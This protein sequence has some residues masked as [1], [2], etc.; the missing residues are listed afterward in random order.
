MVCS[1]AALGSGNPAEERLAASLAFSPKW[2]MALETRVTSPIVDDNNEY[3]PF[4]A[5]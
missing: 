3:T 1:Q 2:R 5:E 4:F